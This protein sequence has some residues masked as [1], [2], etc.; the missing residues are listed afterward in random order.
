MGGI[1]LIV[2]GHIVGGGAH[3]AS[4]AEQIFLCD[5]FQYI[6]S[7]HVPLFFFVAGLT[8]SCRLSFVDFITKKFRRLLIP[9]FIFGFASIIVFSM[10]SSSAY[11]SIAE[12]ETTHYY[13]AKHIG[14]LWYLVVNLFYVGLP[15]GFLENSVLWFIPCLFTLEIIYYGIEK[16]IFRSSNRIFWHL[17][18]GVTAFVLM[19]RLPR[20]IHFPVPFDILTV[21]R[22]LP[23]FAIARCLGTK[24]WIQFNE[25][26]PRRVF[27]GCALLLGLLVSGWLAIH[28]INPALRD[29][30]IGWYFVTGGFALAGIFF[31]SV[32]SQLVAQWYLMTYIG[33]CTMTIMLVHKFPVLFF[34]LKIPQIRVLFTSSVGSAVMGTSCIMILTV[35]ICLAAYSF[36]LKVAPWMIGEYPCKKS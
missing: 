11:Q 33:T 13:D 26:I 31:W 6:Y 9:Y 21:I 16:L 25:S 17:T 20:S 36:L 29:G 32:L 27:A 34:Q 35:S 4:G 28:A 22:Y 23:Y 5:T 18:V 7:Y 3:L 10:F 24:P 2:L 8:F 30:K 12:A 14:S 1:L 19:F 15:N